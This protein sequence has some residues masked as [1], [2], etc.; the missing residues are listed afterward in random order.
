[1][2]NRQMFQTYFVHNTYLI[3]SKH[4]EAKRKF[5]QKCINNRLK[6]TVLLAKEW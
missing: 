5:G 3:M 2:Y 4:G 6:Q 1:M